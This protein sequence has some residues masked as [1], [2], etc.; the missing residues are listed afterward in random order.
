MEASGARARHQQKSKSP[1]VAGAEVAGY[2][3]AMQGD[4]SRRAAG[5]LILFLG[6][7]IVFAMLPYLSGLLT[8]PV[9]AIIWEPLHQRLA[10]RMPVGVAAGIVLLLTFLLIVLPGIWLVTLLIGQAQNAI[11]T[12]AQSPLL[13]RLDEVKLGQISV[14]PMVAQAGQSAL[15]WIGGNALSILGTATR[16]ILSL[17]FAF[18]GLYYLLVRPGEAWRAVA[19]LI[20]FSPDRTQV[21]RDRFEA[22]TW[23]TV[24]GT[25]LNAAVQG[26]LVAVAFFFASVPNAAFWGAVTA[27]LSVLP[28]VGSG[29]VWAPAA[30]SLVLTGRVGAAIALGLWGVLVVANVDNFLRPMVYRRYAHMHPMAT[31]V[32]AV[33]GVEYF[34]MVGLV[35]G[36]LAILYFFELIAMYRTE[37]THPLTSDS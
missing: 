37:Y 10:R 14:G 13:T 18:V 23:S 24:V 26:I 34:G 17:L 31:L 33:I 6:L 16:R 29:L 35:L 36:P 32:G 4:I 20:P 30:V 1:P 27:V 3:G 25:G 2:V 19:P 15:T 11:E 7:A 22:V 12:M 28:L 8:A 5:A 9:L 21:L